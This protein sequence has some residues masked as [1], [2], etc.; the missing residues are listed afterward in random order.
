MVNIDKQLDALFAQL[1]AQIKAQI[2]SDISPMGQANEADW[3][4]EHFEAAWTDMKRRGHD[5][6]WLLYL[7]MTAVRVGDIKPYIDVFNSDDSGCLPVEMVQPTHCVSAEVDT[8]YHLAYGSV[9]LD[10]NNWG[11]AANFKAVV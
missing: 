2:E 7:F 4:D 3:S 5:P 9:T 11:I 10:G 8:A 6:I 1:K